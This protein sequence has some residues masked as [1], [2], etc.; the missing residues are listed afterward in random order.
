MLKSALEKSR[1][2]WLIFYSVQHVLFPDDNFFSIL[3]NA[4][5]FLKDKATRF[6]RYGSEDLRAR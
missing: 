3:N 6:P 2:F 5:G 4:Q 1:Q